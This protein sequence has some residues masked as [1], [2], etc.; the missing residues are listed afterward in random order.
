MHL[1]GHSPG[2]IGLW[3]AAT[4]IFFSG[5]AI[6]DG[7]LS[8]Q[9][10]QSRGPTYLATMERLRKLTPRLVHGG[11]FPSFGGRRYRELIDQY[12]SGKRKS[13][14]ASELHG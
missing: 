10:Y 9:C 4:G 12:V 14:C 3:G 5:H 13:G 1:P 8:D 2:S 7:P 6:Y 11:H